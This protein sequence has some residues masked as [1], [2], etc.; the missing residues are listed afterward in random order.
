VGAPFTILR[1]DQPIHATDIEEADELDIVSA[2]DT[3]ITVQ[4]A[5]QERKILFR[6]GN[7]AQLKSKVH[8]AFPDTGLYYESRRTRW[9]D[10]KDG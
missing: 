7:S 9:E 1:R 5:T 6:Q 4:D 2:W 10:V 8:A 3:T